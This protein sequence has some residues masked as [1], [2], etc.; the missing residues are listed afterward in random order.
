MHDIADGCVTVYVCVCTVVA[1][2]DVCVGVGSVFVNLIVIVYI[3]VVVGG[4]VLRV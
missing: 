1:V 2:F 4:V 3:V